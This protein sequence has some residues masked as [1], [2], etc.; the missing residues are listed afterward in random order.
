[1]ALLALG[2]VFAAGLFCAPV[3]VWVCL[4]RMEGHSLGELC[5]GTVLFVMAITA[6]L[7]LLT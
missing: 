6:I 3:V 7:R 1:M 4:A 5:L 2:I